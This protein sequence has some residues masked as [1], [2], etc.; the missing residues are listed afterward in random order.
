M[1]SFEI[2]LEDRRKYVTIQIIHPGDATNFPRIGSS[3]SF[4]YKI[5]IEKD[6]NYIVVDSSFD[7]SLPISCIVGNQQ[8]IAGIECWLPKISK[9]TYSTLLIP[10]EVR[11][12]ICI[13]IFD[14]F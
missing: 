4:H 6:K 11:F 10:S 3:V 12:F 13:Y 7:R 9:G 5:F 1:D 2:L 8:V 14:F